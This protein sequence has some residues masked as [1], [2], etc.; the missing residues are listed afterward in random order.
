MEYKEV[1]ESGYNCIYC[2]YQ[3]IS[4]HWEVNINCKLSPN[5]SLWMM[6]EKVKNCENFITKKQYIRQQKLNKIINKH[7]E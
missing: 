5:V 4:G 3:D 7:H 6:G 2:V 1:L